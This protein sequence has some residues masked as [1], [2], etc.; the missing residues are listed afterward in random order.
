MA[1]ISNPIVTV[2]QSVVSAA[3][4]GTTTAASK[5]SAKTDA[6]KATDTYNQ[7][8]TLLTTQLQHQD[9]TAP[10]DTN[11]F[12]QQL[13]QF[14]QVEQQL[15]G[16]AKLDTLIANTG[17]SSQISS[18]L[19][20]VGLNATINSSQGVLSNGS[21][22][23]TI[24]APSAADN[25]DVAISDSNGRKIAS[26]KQS[27]KAGDQKITWDGLDSNGNKVTDGIYNIA[28]AGVNSAGTSFTAT[29]KISTQ[30]SGI[31]SSSGTAMLIA[32]NLSFKPEQVVAVSR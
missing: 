5:T 26:Y 18:L 25:A 10:L 11:Q 14:S 29:S 9:P 24:S 15:K 19:G 1:I 7:F 4:N 3:V 8:L 17:S 32:G 20:Y 2:S 27:L 28:V 21:A 23:W 31:D 22:T 6:Q 30:I 13:V 16:N 12:T